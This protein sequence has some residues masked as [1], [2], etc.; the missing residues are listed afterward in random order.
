MDDDLMSLRGEKDDDLFGGFDASDSDLFGGTG[1][2]G[3]AESPGGFGDASSLD[4]GAPASA[5]PTSAG[6]D[7]VPDWLKELKRPD[8]LEPEPA[9]AATATVKKAEKPKKERAKAQAKPKPRRKARS[10]GGITPQQRAMLSLFLFLD[11]AVL[12][13]AILA[14][15][16]IINIP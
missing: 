5:P 9:R 14:G 10:S 15:M 13:C 12:G 16:G 8:D 1:S 4:V 6:E 2:A 11:V 3:G 7:T